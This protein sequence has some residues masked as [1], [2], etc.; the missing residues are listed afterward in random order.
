MLKT[1]GRKVFRVSGR[2]DPDELAKYDLDDDFANPGDIDDPLEIEAWSNLDYVFSHG[3]KTRYSRGN[4]GVAYTSTQVETAV[5]E[6]GYWVNQLYFKK[7]NPPASVD[8][9]EFEFHVDG[10]NRDYTSAPLYHPELTNPDPEQYEHCHKVSD[11]CLAD[12]LEYI[13]APSARRNQGVNI[14][15]FRDTAL[16][17]RAPA[18]VIAYEGLFLKQNTGLLY[19]SSATQVGVAFRPVYPNWHP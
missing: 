3:S 12:E 18:V 15:I 5:F 17:T 7:P 8:V 1:P 16:P 11:E 6:K 19:T 9:L 10:K 14:P 2:P 13:S 4:V